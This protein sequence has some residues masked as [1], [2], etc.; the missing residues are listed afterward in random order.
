MNTV[1]KV[2]TVS[3]ILS[4]SIQVLNLNLLMIVFLNVVA[5]ERDLS[6]K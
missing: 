1:S 4:H 3:T 6:V 2:S 5:Y